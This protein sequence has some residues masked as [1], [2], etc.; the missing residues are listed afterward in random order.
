[1]QLLQFKHV[2]VLIDLSIYLIGRRIED[3]FPVALYGVVAFG[4][5]GVTHMLKGIHLVKQI[6]MVYYS[7]SLFVIVYQLS[8]AVAN[9]PIEL[10][11]FLI[12]LTS[13][14][15]LSRHIE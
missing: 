10:T 6:V 14:V 9:V 7:T 5:F 1:M 12:F 2:P 13:A 3:L 11:H 15:I 8:A 4:L